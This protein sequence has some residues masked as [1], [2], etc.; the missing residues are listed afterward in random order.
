MGNMII[1][2]ILI[3]FV[4]IFTCV[5]SVIICSICDEMISL[6]DSGRT[7]DAI[8]LFNEKRAYLAIFIRDAEIDVV[9]AEAEFLGESISFEDG[10]A[11]AGRMRLREAVTELKNSEK[12]TFQDI[13][14]I[15]IRL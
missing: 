6:I 9:S 8:S 7:D 15:D 3:A 4:I 2:C 13:F 10:E 5:N 14:V 11:E 1:A 12:P